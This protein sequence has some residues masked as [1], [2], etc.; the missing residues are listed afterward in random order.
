MEY[1]HGI[2]V[3]EFKS[4]F[5]RLLVYVQSV[6]VLTNANSLQSAQNFAEEAE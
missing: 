4:C 1:G 2:G 5:D 6:R 3:M